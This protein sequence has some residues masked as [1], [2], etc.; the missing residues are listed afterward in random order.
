[1]LIVSGPSDQTKKN[2]QPFPAGAIL[3]DGEIY[4]LTCIDL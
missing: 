1:M 2:A 3:D 4:K